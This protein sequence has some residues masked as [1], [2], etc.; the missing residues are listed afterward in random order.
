MYNLASPVIILS[1][2]SMDRKTLTKTALGQ[3]F[4]TDHPVVR[5]SQ[6][7]FYLY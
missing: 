1:I 6:V 7:L 2:I 4:V 3:Q 5:H